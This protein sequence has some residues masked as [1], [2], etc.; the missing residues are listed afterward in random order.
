MYVWLR[1]KLLAFLVAWAEWIEPPLPTVETLQVVEEPQVESGVVIR[2]PEGPILTR[3]IELVLA[4]MNEPMTGEAKRHAVYA[5]LIKDFPSTLKREL[6]Q[7]I[8]A[9][10]LDIE[11]T[12]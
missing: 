11:G 4:H 12:K 8:E 5:R 6:A 10:L 1:L 2:V 9:A 3:A 7:S